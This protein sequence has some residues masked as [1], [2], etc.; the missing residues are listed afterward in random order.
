MGEVLEEIPLHVPAELGGSLLGLDDGFANRHNQPIA[1]FG[2]QSGTLRCHQMRCLTGSDP[3]GLRA[4]VHEVMPELHRQVPEGL[5]PYGIDEALVAAPHG[6]SENIEA[7]ML[8][9]DAVEEQ[10]ALLRIGVVDLDRNAHAAAA[11]DLLGGLDDCAGDSIDW[12][13]P[14]GDGSA[15]DID[16]RSL[17]AQSHGDAASAAAAGSGDYCDFAL[18]SV[19]HEFRELLEVSED[20]RRLRWWVTLPAGLRGTSWARVAEPGAAQAEPVT[21]LA[22]RA[23]SLNRRHRGPSEERMRTRLSSWNPA[24]SHP[25]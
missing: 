5:L 22:R 11:R 14:A 9:L 7:A 24:S 23:V 16:G 3:E 19:R 1:P 12:R 15:G 4:S 10:L 21:H 2:A 13:R 6:A 20:A 25:D 18:E 8:G 17:F